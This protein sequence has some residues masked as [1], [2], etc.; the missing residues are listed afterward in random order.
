MRILTTARA[1]FA[2]AALIAALAA[3]PAQAAA[4]GSLRYDAY[5]TVPCNGH[6]AYQVITY[7]FGTPVLTAFAEAFP[8]G[9][10][11]DQVSPIVQ[12]SKPQRTLT[13]RIKITRAMPAGFWAGQVRGWSDRPGHPAVEHD[14]QKFGFIVQRQPISACIQVV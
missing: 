11:R 8:I 9:A 5:V 2:G 10:T 14:S 13:F 1:A 7:T 4:G 3:S 6:P 12:K